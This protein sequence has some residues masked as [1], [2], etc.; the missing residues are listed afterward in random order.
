[1]SLTDKQPSQLRRGQPNTDI[2]SYVNTLLIYL[3][4]N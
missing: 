2:V 3:N 1:M 4:K